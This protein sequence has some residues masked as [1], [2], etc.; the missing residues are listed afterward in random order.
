[1]K[2]VLRTAV[3]KTRKFAQD[4][5]NAVLR[6]AL[7]ILCSVYVQKGNAKIRLNAHYYG[8]TGEIMRL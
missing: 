1:M 2:T 7:T 5:M 4:Y 3:K 6:T 8:Y